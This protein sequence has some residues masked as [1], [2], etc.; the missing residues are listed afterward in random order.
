MSDMDDKMSGLCKFIDGKFSKDTEHSNVCEVKGT[1]ILTWKSDNRVDIKRGSLD[2]VFQ[3]NYS[4]ESR[5]D[6]I[7]IADTKDFM[8]FEGGKN[9]V[10]IVI[11]KEGDVHGSVTRGENS[12]NKPIFSI[13]TE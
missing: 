5:P 4:Y 10:H 2:L 3:G 11:N 7:A 9:A 13:F 1:K 8:P 12:A 6:A